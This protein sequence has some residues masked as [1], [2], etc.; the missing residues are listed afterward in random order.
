MP[1]SDL[2]S[3]TLNAALSEAADWLTAAE[4]TQAI[5]R[6]EDLLSS[7]PDAVRVLGVRARALQ[8]AGE[9]ARAAQDYSRVLDITPTDHQAMSGLMRCQLRFGQKREA[10]VTAGQLLDHDPGNGDAARLLRDAGADVN[11]AGRVLAARVKFAAGLTNQAVAEIRAMASAT[12]DRVDLQV[13]LA[14]MLWRTGLR[15]TTAELCQA[16]L[17][18]QPDCLNANV[19]LYALWSVM[20]TG[21]MS[22]VHLRAVERLDPDCRETV[23]W[24][25]ERSPLPVR[26]MPAWIEPSRRVASVEPDEDER[27]RSEWV[28]QLIASA[29][30]GREAATGL[31]SDVGSVVAAAA[32]GI[33]AESARH[34]RPNRDEP[35]V[36]AHTQDA[37]FIFPPPSLD[38][39]S[40]EISDEAAAA[41]DDQAEQ[42]ASEDNQAAE[43]DNDQGLPAWLSGLRQQSAPLDE[44]DWVVMPPES[45]AQ[46]ASEPAKEIELPDQ[47]I[48][49]PAKE[50]ELPAQ[51]IPEPA[52]EVA[53]ASRAESEL[54]HAP[55]RF[56]R[57]VPSVDVAANMTP[58]EWKPAEADDLAAT[59]PVAPPI[60]SDLAQ[61]ESLPVIVVQGAT[62]L[63]M[64]PATTAVIPSQ[65]PNVTLAP[66]PDTKGKLKLRPKKEKLSVEHLLSLAR[67][68][69]E[70]AE[71][72]QAAQYYARLVTAGKK[73]DEVQSDLD[74]ATHAYPDVSKF[75]SL[76]GR[77]YTRKGN[78]DAALAA[79]Q[80]A[81]AL[82]N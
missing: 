16:I 56:T 9:V 74:V 32:S 10:I 66:R 52:E 51:A 8:A 80:R 76:L 63:P 39:R 26:D 55:S 69:M 65:T 25:G 7:Y 79:Y 42:V 64:S 59:L 20:G 5:A 50:I 13:V 23:S 45:T 78:L 29:A 75:H 4:Y 3:L 73:L 82:E 61:D 60:A 62:A 1:M 48:L 53:T 19:I 44:S 12:P 6:C 38:W 2:N 30:P 41:A 46:A 31:P 70:A 28:D 22:A 67:R 72:D 37:Q 14:E 40:D 27:D 49:E 43:G 81:L 21:N 47:A 57:P 15:I 34:A 77:V 71:Y 35:G 11:A 18:M 54:A 17:D 33:A 68:S 24:L 58:L 36:R